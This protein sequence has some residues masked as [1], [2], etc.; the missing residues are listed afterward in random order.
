MSRTIRIVISLVVLGLVCS[1]GALIMLSRTQVQS[2]NAITTKP[3]IRDY[4][5]H[6]L[7]FQLVDQDNTSVNESAL[8]GHW[9][10]VDF[11][12]TNCISICPVMTSRMAQAQARFKD[13][14][15]RYAS[16]SLDAAHDTPEASKAYAQ[17]YG[18][19]FNT[20]LFLTGDNAQTQRLV[21]QGLNLVVDKDDFDITLNDG[22]TMRNILHPSRLFLVAPDLK[23]VGMY[24]SAD[25]AELDR[26]ESDLSGLIPSG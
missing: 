20:W 7:P 24:D 11:Y 4:G 17:R 18:A 1:I 5:M 14:P 25:P 6:I 15:L 21:R 23:I 19:D 2:A 9:T 8:R 13:L 22:S 26:L 12:F 3:N 16:F 10:L